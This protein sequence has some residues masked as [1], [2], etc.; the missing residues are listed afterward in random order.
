MAFSNLLAVLIV[1]CPCALG[2]ATSMSVMVGIGKGA[3]NG[4]LIKNSEA[5]EKMEKADVL[6]VDKTGTITSGKPSVS[7]VVSGNA[8]FQEKDILQIAASVNKNST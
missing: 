5:L 1:A 4:I 7:E 2:L 3:K 6:I 8:K